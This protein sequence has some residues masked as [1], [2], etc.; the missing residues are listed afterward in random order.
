MTP[1]KPIT[2]D[3]FKLLPY[4][5]RAFS[6]RAEAE[7]LENDL[8]AVYEAA[9]PAIAELEKRWPEISQVGRSL[10]AAIAPEYADT[11][12]ENTKA[13]APTTAWIQEQLRIRGFYKGTIDGKYGNATS[14][15]VEAFQ[16]SLGWVGKAVDGVAGPDT[17]GA[18]LA[19]P[20]K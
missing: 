7:L 11:V 8:R 9:K 12:L 6:H 16:R 3:F 10:I 17:V 15:A 2:I 1:F 18:M 20:V 13:W 5:M 19:H 14:A 4:A